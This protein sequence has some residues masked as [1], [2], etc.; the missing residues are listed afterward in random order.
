MTL[1][2]RLHIH[3]SDHGSLRFDES[4]WTVVI[5]DSTVVAPLT[6]PS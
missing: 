3:G 5:R 6:N 4:L 1:K 2:A